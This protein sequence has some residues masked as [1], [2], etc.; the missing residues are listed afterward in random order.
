[1]PI[2]ILQLSILKELFSLKKA[3]DFYAL[4]V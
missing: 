1:M 2:F 4:Q 3:S